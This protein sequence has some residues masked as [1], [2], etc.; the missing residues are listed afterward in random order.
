VAIIIH[1]GDT[2]FQG[3]TE[4]ADL[5]FPLP[6]LEQYLPRL[7]VILFDLTAIADDDPIL[8]DPEVPELKVVLMVLKTI[9]R[10][11]GEV[12]LTLS[13][14][15]RE[16]K[17]YSDDPVT[18]RIIRATWFYLANNARY[19]RENPAAL[20]GIFREVITGENDMRTLVEVW[21]AEGKAEGEAE[22]RRGTVLAILEDRFGKIPSEIIDLVNSYS[23]QIAL[24]SIA[25]RAASCKTLDEF[26]EGL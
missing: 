5:F 2:R 11:D 21:K 7:R 14:V 20:S 22:G 6:G 12:A 18:R 24:K 23:D 4:L 17:P 10:H 15:L 13:D 8:N 16:L 9:F 19:L 25:V 3:A 26:K 1:H